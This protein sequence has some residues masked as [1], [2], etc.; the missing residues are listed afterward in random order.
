MTDR[1]WGRPATAPF[2]S[3]SN[4]SQNRASS[5]ETDREPSNVAWSIEKHDNRKDE[6]HDCDKQSDD[7]DR[8]KYVAKA[9]CDDFS[10]DVTAITGT[11]KSMPGCKFHFDPA[12]VNVVH[13]NRRERNQ[14]GPKDRFL[15]IEVGL[16]LELDKTDSGGLFALNASGIRRS[17]ASRHAAGVILTGIHPR[18][19]KR[20]QFA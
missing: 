13:E 5:N 19:E 9:G 12:G 20:R 14:E 4:R 6:T 3:P 16:P 10:K 18:F 2:K 15:G 8:E 17:V 7:Q 11:A 1:A